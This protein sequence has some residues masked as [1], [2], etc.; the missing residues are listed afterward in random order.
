M[1]ERTQLCRGAAQA[2]WGYLFLFLDVTLFGFNV[3]PNFV[4]YALFLAAI[5]NLSAQRRDL[6]LL[7]PLGLLL[8]VWNLALWGAG[9][10]GVTLASRFL[11]LDALVAVAGLYFH[12]QFFTDCAALAALYSGG[13]LER[14]L[15]R[16]RTVLVVLQTAVAVLAHLPQ[17]GGDVQTAA[18]TALLLI[19][20][21]TVFFLMRCMFSLR[22]L[23]ADSTLAELAAEEAEGSAPPHL[24]GDT[25]GASN[26]PDG[27]VEADSS[28]DGTAG[29]GCSP[30]GTARADGSLSNLP[31]GANSPGADGSPDSTP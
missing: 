14:R 2:A 29:T 10:W 15:L 27:A 18:L 13:T 3:L 19:S 17:T 24:S 16:W 6:R 25:A 30:D 1:N 5:S 12:F 4:G 8:L 9:L 28:P 23:F 21:L 7:R 31:G 11:I 26:F 22:R 20:T